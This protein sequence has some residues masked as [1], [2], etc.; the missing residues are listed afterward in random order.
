MGLILYGAASQKFYKAWNIFV[1]TMGISEFSTGWKRVNEEEIHP[2][3]VK[4]LKRKVDKIMNEKLKKISKKS[5]LGRTIRGAKILPNIPG[6]TVYANGRTYGYKAVQPTYQWIDN[7]GHG[8]FISS[9][10]K[11][12]R[13]LRKDKK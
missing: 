4:I 3:M 2:N 11:I 1:K 13:K 12:Y 6:C 7:H 5:H 9:P 10:M 8:G